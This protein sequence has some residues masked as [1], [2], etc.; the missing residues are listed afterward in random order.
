MP[1]IKLLHNNIKRFVP[2][3]VILAVIL[4]ILIIFATK[5]ATHNAFADQTTSQN[6]HLVKT[7]SYEL[8]D[9]TNYQINSN[10][11]RTNPL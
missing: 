10:S 11:K 7:T 1:N 4:S 5:Q 8:A 9:N 6:S 3:V 2:I